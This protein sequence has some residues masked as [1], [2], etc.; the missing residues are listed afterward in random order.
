MGALRAATLLGALSI[1][2]CATQMVQQQARDACQ[3]Q[4]KQALVVNQQHSGIPLLIESAGATYYCVRPDQVVHTR[5]AFG[6]DAVSVPDLPGAAVLSVAPASLAA[7]AGLQSGD[8][9]YQYAGR[10]IGNA[11]EL[12]QAVADTAAGSLVE[13]RLRRNDKEVAARVQF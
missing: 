2:G 1:A 8:A 9:I 6:V 11:G 7:R 12:Q 13:V 10:T 4:G 5:D 3:K